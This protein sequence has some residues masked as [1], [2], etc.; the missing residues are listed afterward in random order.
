MALAADR[1]DDRCWRAVRGGAVVRWRAG[2]AGWRCGGVAHRGVVVGAPPTMAQRGHDVELALE[3]SCWPF[4]RA[5]V[6]P[7][8]EY[9]W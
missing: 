1:R 7:L 3:Q 2:A 8:A 4:D 6:R 5:A 9:S